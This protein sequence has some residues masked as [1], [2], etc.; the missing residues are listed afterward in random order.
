MN[1]AIK[2]SINKI[3][4]IIFVKRCVA[5]K[6]LLP[7][8]YDKKLCADC[9]AEWEESKTEICADCLKEQTECHC[10]FRNNKVDSV[11]HLALYSH[12]DNEAVTNRL[13]YALKRSN[14]DDV[15]EFVADEIIDNLITKKNLYNT[16][17]VSV[18]R[19][20]NS[21]RHYGYDHA[22]TLAKRIAEKLDIEYVDIL[23]HK[24][25]KSEQKKLNSAQRSENAKKNCYINEKLVNKIKGKRVFLIDDIGTTG[26]M[27][28]ACTKLLKDNGAYRVECILAAK[29]ESDG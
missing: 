3:L 25:G 5:C 12:Y 20:P 2:E 9:L 29:N 1:K 17:C 10:R 8:D 28:C 18:P 24:G 7:Y 22:K 27:V 19:N 23:K 14:N 11:R 4:N 13:I 6:K 21:I 26:S 15:F 16:V